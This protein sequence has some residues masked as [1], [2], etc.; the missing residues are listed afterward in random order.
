MFFDPSAL[1]RL[2]PHH[3][4]A[5]ILGA[6]LA[7]GAKVGGEP[8]GEGLPRGLLERR[9]VRRLAVHLEEA[10]ENLV[11]DVFRPVRAAPLAPPP[12][13]RRDL[14]RQVVSGLRVQK[15]EGP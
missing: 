3:L 4:I 11:R 9:K 7:V 10:L 15:I 5:V 2:P 12:F 1:P 6:G 13:D 14:G 8:V